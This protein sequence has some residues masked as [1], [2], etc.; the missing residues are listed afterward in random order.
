MD[1]PYLSERQLTE[2]HKSIVQYLGSKADRDSDNDYTLLD[3]LKKIYELEK[4]LQEQTKIIEDYD[5][6]LQNGNGST[7]TR[8]KYH[9]FPKRVR[10]T[11]RYH[12]ASVTALAFHPYNP[13]L[14][15]AGQDG[16]HQQ[17][18]LSAYSHF[19]DSSVYLASASSDLL[20]KIWD[21]NSTAYNVPIRTLSGHSHLVSAALFSKIDPS[22]L[23]TSSRDCTIKVWDVTSGWCIKTIQGHSDWVRNL[24]LVS[25]SEG[26]EFLLSCSN[27]QSVRLTHL[28][29]GTGIGLC[30]GHEQVVED[31]VFIPLQRET[32]EID[33]PLYLKLNYKYCASCGRDNLIKIWKLP[34]PD[35]TTGVPRP[36][37][38]PRGKLVYQIEGHTTWVRKLAIH[39][40]GQFLVSCS[41]DKTIKF[42]DL[43]S[44]FS[45]IE[46]GSVDASASGGIRPTVILKDHE[47]F[48]NVIR[49]ADPV[50]A[51]DYAKFAHSTDEKDQHK[52]KKL[53][54]QGIRCYL[55]SGSADNTVKVW[56]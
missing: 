34:L 18:L 56:V 28:N 22:K 16:D 27:D 43:K 29:S 40:N 4:Q 3:Y 17:S 41:D 1:S 45:A 25:D 51:D 35:L 38:D 10:A 5:T 24:D 50:L 9:W 23:V 30:I 37:A 39:P 20:V 11:L 49:F 2:L 6:L 42:W 12:Q 32:K 7:V 26:D 54:A 36:S 52:A 15:T 53:L 44:I 48:V 33:D 47:N 8:D 55:A 19:S 31:V 21:L 46:G 14:V 13:I